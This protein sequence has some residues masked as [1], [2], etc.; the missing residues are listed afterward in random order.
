MAEARPGSHPGAVSDSLIVPS[1][2][3]IAP[4]RPGTVR[5]TCSILK[6]KHIVAL[7]MDNSV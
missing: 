3:G 2:S 6:Y 1:D 7:V 4:V 5:K